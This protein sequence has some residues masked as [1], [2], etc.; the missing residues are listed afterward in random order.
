MKR[1]GLKNSGAETEGRVPKSPR[2]FA[3]SQLAVDSYQV[4]KM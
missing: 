3:R 4:M 1:I 2:L